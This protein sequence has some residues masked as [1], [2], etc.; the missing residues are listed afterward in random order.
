MSTRPNRTGP[1]DQASSL[2]YQLAS[3]IQVCLHAH[4]SETTSVPHEQRG[5][6]RVLQMASDLAGELIDQVEH[7]E[8]DLRNEAAKGG[9][10]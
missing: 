3:M 7:L 2:A 8:I 5:I 4:E 1:G 9:E 6:D 10:H